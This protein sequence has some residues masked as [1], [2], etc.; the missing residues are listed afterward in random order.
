MKRGKHALAR[1]SVSVFD[2]AERS[3]INCLQG[4]KENEIL[5]KKELDNNIQSKDQNE[6]EENTQDKDPNILMLLPLFVFAVVIII[7]GLYSK[8][9]VDFFYK[10]AGL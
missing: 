10:V 1:E 7:L 4:E 6:K 5:N 2:G 8:P 9:F 3:G